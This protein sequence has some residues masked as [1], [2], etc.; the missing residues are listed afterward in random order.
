MPAVL[1]SGSWWPAVR[2]AV[3]RLNDADDDAGAIR[4]LEELAQAFG[5]SGAM[6]SHLVRHDASLTVVASPSFSTHR[7]FPAISPLGR[8]QVLVTLEADR[9]PGV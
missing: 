5:A 8:A 9:R 1:H 3:Q 2:N 6:F 4:A 7:C